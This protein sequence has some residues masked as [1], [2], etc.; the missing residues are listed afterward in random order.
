MV[1]HSKENPAVASSSI[2]A[3]SSSILL[4]F[5]LWC[6]TSVVNLGE[7]EQKFVTRAQKDSLCSSI[8]ARVLKLSLLE[9]Q[10][11]LYTTDHLQ[12]YSDLLV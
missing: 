5:L 9:H 8:C 1:A 4:D 6:G 12:N 10:D 3:K 11:D 7:D 2:L